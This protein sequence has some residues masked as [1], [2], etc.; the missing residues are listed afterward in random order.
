MFMTN[1]SGAPGW[2]GRLYRRGNRGTSWKAVPLPGGVE[3]SLYF[4]ATNPADPIIYSRRQPLA[5][6]IVRLTEERHGSG[7]GGDWAKLGDRMGAGG[8]VMRAFT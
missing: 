6:R 4:L 5:G 3:S 1:G 2:H 8:F 7:W